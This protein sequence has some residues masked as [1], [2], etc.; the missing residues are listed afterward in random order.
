MSISGLCHGITL[1]SNITGS[2]S[3]TVSPYLIQIVLFALLIILFKTCTLGQL[4]VIYIDNVLIYVPLIWNPRPELFKVT[5]NLSIYKL[6][7]LGEST[8]P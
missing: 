7:R 4:R 6:N 8:L 5:N 1:S 3:F 2:V